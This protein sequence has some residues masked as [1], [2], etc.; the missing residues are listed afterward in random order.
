MRAAIDAMVYPGSDEG[1]W[2]TDVYMRAYDGR[3]INIDAR[4]RELTLADVEA[5]RE[6]L[7]AAGYVEVSSWIP[8]QGVSWLSSGVSSGASF[9]IRKVAPE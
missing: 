1:R 5:F 9:E 8:A 3:I 6:A 4:T 2:V 7:T